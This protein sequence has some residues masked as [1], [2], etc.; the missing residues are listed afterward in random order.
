MVETFHLN[1]E[2]VDY[3]AFWDSL[4]GYW[5][6]RFNTLMLHTITM[7]DANAAA[8]CQVD[9]FCAIG[10]PPNYYDF[11]KELIHLSDT[12]SDCNKCRTLCA[13]KKGCTGA[14][15]RWCTFDRLVDQ[16]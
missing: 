12:D 11:G 2:L 14:Y 3:T 6:T 16:I 1:G 4:V 9:R 13:A 10:D 5:L 8:K 15:H 7:H